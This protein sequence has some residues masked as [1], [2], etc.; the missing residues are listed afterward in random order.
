MAAEPSTRT[1][2]L[3]KL[4]EVFIQRGF[5]GATLAHLSAA[6]EL[7]KAT[8]YHHFPGGKNEIIEQLIRFSIAQLQTAAFASLH[9]ADPPRDKIVGLISGFETYLIDSNRGC[10]L[11][12]LSHHEANNDELGP[13][14]KMIADQF[15]DWQGQ[16][17]QT[18]AASGMKRKKS[19]RQ[20]SELI[21]GLYGALVT[22]RL[23]N[24]PKL[25][26]N[27]LERLRKHHAAS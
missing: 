21:A 13:H 25:L 27:L 22:S 14:Q 24:D 19:A 11:A 3:I 4:R 20:A 6:S 17:S 26:T 23:H 7:S 18:F 12:V 16:L 8:L 9:S 10:L 2:L 1:E 15:A 5:D